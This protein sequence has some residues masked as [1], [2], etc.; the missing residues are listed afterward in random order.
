M[1]S[2]TTA[3]LIKSSHSITSIQQ[4]PELLH[5]FANPTQKYT[6]LISNSTISL[7]IKFRSNVRFHTILIFPL[8]RLSRNFP[9]SLF[10]NLVPVFR[11]DEILV[12]MRSRAAS[13]SLVPKDARDK[14]GECSSFFRRGKNF[15]GRNAE[16]TRVLDKTALSFGTATVKL[17][18]SRA[19]CVFSVTWVKDRER[20]RETDKKEE[21]KRDGSERLI[22]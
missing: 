17:Q 18:R 6:F 9:L 14:R 20:E 11:P 5:F 13:F 2:F 19:L 12:C 21:N 22:V 4:Q 3:S 15:Y 7:C 1:I 16:A 10:A 8:R